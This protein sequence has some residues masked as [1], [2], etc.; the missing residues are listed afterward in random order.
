[1]KGCNHWDQ[2]CHV[3]TNEESSQCA[4][5][6]GVHC[7]NLD[8]WKHYPESPFGDVDICPHG[9]VREHGTTSDRCRFCDI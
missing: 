3:M 1:M 6:L 2:G 7:P 5:G 4:N 9:V 8:G